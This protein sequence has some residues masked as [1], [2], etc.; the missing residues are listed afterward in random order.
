MCHEFNTVTIL[1]LQLHSS[2]SI[3]GKVL[4][5]CVSGNSTVH[6]FA[7]NADVGWQKIFSP[8]THS[9]HVI[10]AVDSEDV[11]DSDDVDDLMLMLA[12]EERQQVEAYST[13]YPVILLLQR[14]TSPA[15]EFA[16]SGDEFRMLDSKVSG[17]YL[18]SV[19]ITVIG[20]DSDVATVKEPESFC[21]AADEFASCA[22]EGMLDH[23]RAVAQ[24][25][26]NGDSLS[27]CR[28]AK[29]DHPQNGD[30]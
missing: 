26:I 4:S 20:A 15:Y 18:Q 13:E 7:M 30:P 8:S 9:L 3:C 27:Q 1:M 23:R 5:R 22:T 10:K 11:V 16:T 24:H 25:C 14:L 29:F 2:V 28:R 19:S 17:S 6:G 12:D 21:C